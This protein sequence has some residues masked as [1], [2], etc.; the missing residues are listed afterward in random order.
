MRFVTMHGVGGP[1]VLALAEAP[2][3]QPR[4]G[5]V[6]IEVAAAGVN[7]P[8]LVQRAGRYP[9]PPGASPIL[10]LEVAGTIAALGAAVDTVRPGDA[11]CALTPGGGYA[12]FV[13]APALHC[14][15]VP[16]GLSLIEAA[17][18][19]ETAFT[20]WTNVFD[21][22][23][24]V[25]GEHF[26][27]HGGTSGIG[28]IAIQLAAA[29]GA[30]VIATAGTDARCAVCRELGAAVAINH[31]SEDFVDAALRATDGR[32]VDVILDMVGG[33]YV[34]RNLRALA[35]EGRL[36]Q[37][38]FMTGAK[39]SLDLTTVMTRRLT[40]TGSTLRPRS[41]AD[42]AAIAAALRREVWPLID[43]RR[44]RPILHATFPL[45]Q[46]RDAHLAL[47]RGDH[48]GKIVLTMERA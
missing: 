9:P 27:V 28:T 10:G 14:L 16:K 33:E 48:V 31:R 45:E 24:L 21:R 12:E 35:I 26:L 2:P 39:V 11:V 22:A 47:E 43:Q 17:A 1:D 20:V 38:A 15:P 8:D 34:A 42:K 6:L 44:V 37:I 41:I 29:R 32:G 23:R 19:P 30:R 40:L 3:P 46:V 36:V 5:E 18:L 25:A 13:V 7:R 4:S